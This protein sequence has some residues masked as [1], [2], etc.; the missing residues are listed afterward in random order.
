MKN[1]KNNLRAVA[2]PGLGMLHEPTAPKRVHIAGK[3]TGGTRWV[4]W[5][6]WEHRDEAAAEMERWLKEHSPQDWMNIEECSPECE[7]TAPHQATASE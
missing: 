3:I 1:T 4:S 5:K 2:L 6:S 7:H